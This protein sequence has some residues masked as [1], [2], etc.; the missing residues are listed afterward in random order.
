MRKIITGA[1]AAA[2][3]TIALAGCS[4][5]HDSGT[6]PSAASSGSS[7]PAASSSNP[8]FGQTVTYKDGLQITVG[9]PSPYTPSDSAAGATQPVNIQFPITIKNGTSKNF[10]PALVTV[11]ASSGGTEGSQITDVANNNM[12][13]PPTTDILPGSSLSW[14]VAFS[15][16]DQASINLQVSPGFTDDKVIFTN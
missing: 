14:N 15:V 3:L 11:A 16:A 1:L 12:G 8:K 4:V 6:N 13:L 9:T 10:S 7:S 5:G 2:S